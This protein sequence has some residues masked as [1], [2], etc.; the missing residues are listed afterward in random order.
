M[1]IIAKGFTL[2]EL[3][4]VV[5]II[6]ILAAIALPQYQ[7]YVIR[8]NIAEGLVLASAAK[9]AVAETYANTNSGAIGGYYEGSGPNTSCHNDLAAGKVQACYGFE[10]YSTD[11]VEKIVIE[12]MPDVTD[13]TNKAG[14]GTGNLNGRI[15]I[16]FAG[17]TQKALTS[18]SGGRRLGLVLIPGSGIPDGGGS[19][20]RFTSAPSGFLEPGKPIV[21][22]CAVSAE[23]LYGNGAMTILTVDSTRESAY[24]YVP[25]NCRH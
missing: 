16:K 21:W 12:A 4:I 13:T 10:F 6:G 2:V 11:K 17:K 3:M 8:A 19:H 14:A 5:A 23:D 22:T 15:G 7:D 18:R 20:T 25:A 24:R 1:K 9:I